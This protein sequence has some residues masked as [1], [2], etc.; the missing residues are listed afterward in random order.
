[1]RVR[2]ALVGACLVLAG[3]AAGTS[4]GFSATAPGGWKDKTD[5]AE[6]R[7]GSDFEVV[8]EGTEVNGVPP[9]LSVSRVPLPQTGSLEKS[10]ATARLAVDRRFAEADPTRLVPD[11]LDGEPA[12]RFDYRT[13]EKRARYLSA[14]RGSHVYAVAVQAPAEAFDRALVVMEGYLASWRWDRVR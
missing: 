12:L 13:G 3:C 2:A 6:A 1:M 14:R 5:T 9:N 8:Y 11:T 7:T 10:V 4:N